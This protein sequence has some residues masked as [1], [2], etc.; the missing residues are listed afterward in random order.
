MIRNIVYKKEIKIFKKK[1]RIAIMVLKRTIFINLYMK[2]KINQLK[3]PIMIL[4]FRKK[5][6]SHENSD[7]LSAGW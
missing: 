2:F 5:N 7:V 1:L 3:D 4:E 6:S